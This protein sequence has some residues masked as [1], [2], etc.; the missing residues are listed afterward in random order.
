VRGRDELHASLGDG[1]GCGGLLLGPDLVDDDDLRHVVL[2]RLDHHRVLQRRRRD[3]HPA[4]ATDARMGNVAVA[5]D[6]VRGVDDHDALSHL[7]GED[8]RDLAEQRGLADAGTAK[9]QDAAT[10]FDDIPDDLH[11]PVDRAADAEG[12][13]DDFAGTVAERRDA[14]QR[15]LDSRAVVAAE[16][17]DV[18]DDVG[19]VLRR[20]LALRER[21]L[22]PGEAR[23]RE[24]P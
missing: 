17:P 4:G 18:A 5:C 16:L 23:L 10:G 22:A 9:Q 19:E 6:L 3:L 21:L 1:A 11:R 15:P 14:V 8:A 20:D 2:D 24:P 12:E 13:P 7:V